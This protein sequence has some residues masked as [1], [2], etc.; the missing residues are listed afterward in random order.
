M[1]PETR[2]DVAQDAGFTSAP[3]PPSTDPRMGGLGPDP[4]PALRGA[5]LWKK[6]GG[7]SMLRPHPLRGSPQPWGAMPVSHPSSQRTGT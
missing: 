3:S 7:G 4:A 6:P 2:P 1:Q 5:G